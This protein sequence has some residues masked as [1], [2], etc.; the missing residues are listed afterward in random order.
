MD[1]NFGP[2]GEYLIYTIY[3]WYMTVPAAVLLLWAC[4]H[5]NNSRNMRWISGI[6]AAVLLFPVAVFVWY[7]LSGLIEDGMNRRER[8]RQK[9]RHTF[10]LR[11]PE[12][13]AGVAFS[14]GDTIYYARD[15]DMNNRKQ[16]QLSDIDSVRLSK[17]TRFFNLQVKGVI[18]VDQYHSWHVTLTHQQPVFGWPCI[19]DVVIG[20]DSTFVKGTLADDYIALGYRLPKGSEVTYK[21]LLITII[22]PNSKWLTIDAETKQPLSAEDTK[23]ADSLKHSS[24]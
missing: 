17:P 9:I 19:G 11:Q 6:G 14:A 24:P 23:L 8:E 13:T 5:K 7:L 10:I 2:F 16:A 4:L 1:F 3:F 18:G 12:T 21:D 15:L 22:L 20:A